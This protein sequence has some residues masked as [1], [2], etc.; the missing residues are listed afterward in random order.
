MD[1]FFNSLPKQ[2]SKL[3]HVPYGEILKQPMA[4]DVD[5]EVIKAFADTILQMGSISDIFG[6]I[7]DTLEPIPEGEEEEEDEEERRRRRTFL[8]K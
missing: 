3:Q 7:H 1:A 2:S 8:C 5:E 6:N 4:S